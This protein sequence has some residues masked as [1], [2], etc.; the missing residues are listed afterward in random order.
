M[1]EFLAL[2][3]LETGSESDLQLELPTYPFDK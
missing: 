1:T 2:E 3:P